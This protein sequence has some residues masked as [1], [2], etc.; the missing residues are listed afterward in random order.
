MPAN[1]LVV[2]AVVVLIAAG[3]ARAADPLAQNAALH[4][5][6]ATALMPGPRGLDKLT[7]DEQT[8]IDA[9]QTAPIDDTTRS[10]VKKHTR[11]LIQFH[12]GAEL[13]NCAWSIDNDLSRDCMPLDPH[14]HKTRDVAFVAL[15]RARVRFAD[16]EPL[17]AVDD[18][19]AVVRLARHLNGT[20]DLISMITGWGLER[21]AIDVFAANLGSV[22]D[23]GVVREASARWAK[24]KPPRPLLDVLTQNRDEFV[25]WMYN[26]SIR[27]PDNVPDTEH[28]PVGPFLAIGYYL[29][30]QTREQ[31]ATRFGRLFAKNYDRAI[32]VADLPVGE[33]LKAENEVL[34]ALKVIDPKG[35]LDE[36]IVKA[37]SRLM[38]PGTGRLRFSEAEVQARRAMLRAALAI[39]AGGPDRLKE[40][41]DPFGDGPFEVRPVEGGYELKSGLGKVIGRPVVLIVRHTRSDK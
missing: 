31:A 7:D 40:H 10:A 19:V 38:L 26:H 2:A 41:P 15:L 18:L 5:W 13:P 39:A 28:E 36:Q 20:G 6:Q 32:V 8:R 33:V 24:V 29:G 30:L 9:P 27:D 16:G 37:F 22:I 12:R 23:R 4:Y 25:A 14:T 11:A 3:G 17:K 21:Q 35:D 1:R 34:D